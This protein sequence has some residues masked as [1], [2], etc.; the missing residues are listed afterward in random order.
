MAQSR[1]C[2]LHATTPHHS[3]GVW[4]TQSPCNR[5]RGS[6]RPCM[7]GNPGALQGRQFSVMALEPDCLGL[8]PALP[9]GTR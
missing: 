3:T 7:E 2:A 5:S 1:V 8:N 9:L 6:T 4:A